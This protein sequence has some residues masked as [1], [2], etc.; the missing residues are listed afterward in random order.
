MNLTYTNTVPFYG[1]ILPSLAVEVVKPRTWL[2]RASP[3]RALRERLALLFVQVAYADVRIFGIIGPRFAL[4][5]EIL[6][7][8]SALAPD[9][10]VNCFRFLIDLL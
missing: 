8:Y 10:F 3:E 9:R 1:S 7:T 2:H 5:L 4:L 6:G